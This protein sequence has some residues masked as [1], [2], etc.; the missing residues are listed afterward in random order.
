MDKYTNFSDFIKFEGEQLSNEIYNEIYDN[1]D[2]KTIYK[3]LTDYQKDNFE[4]EIT[5]EDL[6]GSNKLKFDNFFLA[7]NNLILSQLKKN[8]FENDKMYI[9]FYNNI[10][11][12][13]LKKDDDESD[14]NRLLLLMKFI[15]ENKRYKEIKDEY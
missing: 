14:A 3:K 6:I 15:F 2:Y 10:C 9:N 5:K 7:A 12:P 4:N 11:E 8:D 1:E 13:L